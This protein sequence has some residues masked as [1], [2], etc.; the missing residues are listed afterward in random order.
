MS[1]NL[2]FVISKENSGKGMDGSLK[3]KKKVRERNTMIKAVVWPYLVS[4]GSERAP[5]LP[6][7]MQTHQ[8]TAHPDH[9]STR[10]DTEYQEHCS[11]VHKTLSHPGVCLKQWT[12]SE[13]WCPVF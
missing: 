11:C 12:R 3:M 10:A 9:H 8:A 7:S 4:F 1:L 6:T 5:L 13:S 2:W